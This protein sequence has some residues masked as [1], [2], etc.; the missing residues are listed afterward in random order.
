[1]K[2]SRHPQN[3]GLL[4]LVM[5]LLTGLFHSTVSGQHP[6]VSWN[7]GEIQKTIGNG[8]EANSSEVQFTVS[9][10]MSSMVVRPN[11]PIQPYISVEPSIFPHLEPGT[12]YSVRIVY[13]LPQRSREGVHVGSIRLHTQKAGPIRNDLKVTIRVEFGGAQ[14]SPDVLTLSRETLA[15]ITSASD[16]NRSLVF[17]QQNAETNAVRP[18]RLLALPPA[19]HIPNG[20]FG[21]VTATTDSAGGFVVHT[22]PA[23]FTEAFSRASI[24]FERSLDDGPS[25][26]VAVLERGASMV[27]ASGR[28]AADSGFTVALDDLILYDDGNGGTITVDGS[29]TLNPRLQ[30]SLDIEDSTL[31][32]LAFTIGLDESSELNVNSS[33]E[34]LSLEAEREFGSYRWQPIVV[35]VGWVPLVFVPEATFVARADGT[36]S[37]GI[38]TGV[39]QAAASRIGFGFSNGSWS[40]IHDLST[41]FGYSEPRFSAAADLKGLAG[42]RFKLLLYG[43][44]GPRADFGVYGELEVDPFDTPVWQLFGGV[45]ANAGIRMEIFDETIADQQ[46]PFLLQYR[47]LLAEGGA[48]TGTIVGSVRDAVTNQPLPNSIVAV[49]EDGNLDDTILTNSAGLFEIEANSAASYRFEISHSGYLPITYHDVTVLPNETKTLDVILQIDEDH[50]GNGNV[51]GSVFNA[52]TG[53]GVQGLT[54]NLRLGLNATTGAIVRSGSTGPGGAYA[55]ANL[56]AG[57]YTAEV[58]GEGFVTSYFAVLCIGNST[59]PNQN[60]TI[61]PIQPEGQVRIVLT[62]GAAPADLDSH[63]F[64]PLPNGSRFHMY[65]PYSGSSSPW[66]TIVTLDLDD[67]TSFGPETTTL[68]QQIPGVYRF[69]VHDYTNRNSS[70]SSA[71]SQSQANVRV[72]R[73]ASLVGSFNVPLGQPGTLWTVFELDGLT[74]RPVNTMTFSTAP[75]GLRGVAEEGA[76][77]LP[78]K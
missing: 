44:V 35:W 59:R 49:Y 56:P 57:N 7:S 50:A 37:V 52:L 55:F 15:L 63:F 19:S 72:Y 17:S 45:E 2:H 29:V 33:V 60:G 65:Y 36:A 20:F 25:L 66:P 1:M 58:A 14:P 46:F 74:V 69:A 39:T 38:T 54:I 24:N 76:L 26:Q 51:S 42:P 12:T 71:L 21:R 28:T 77:L 34:L 48:N 75:D 3:I 23:S 30:F 41:S 11:T 5:L 10:P 18:G 31:N 64:G 43:V 47:I 16:D 53:V 32:Q 22:V 73:G 9:H 27:A 70:T 78:N 61:T 8:S 6:E 4:M 67:V 62:W 68:F 40:S 13:H